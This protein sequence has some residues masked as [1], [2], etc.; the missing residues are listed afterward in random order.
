MVLEIVGNEL[1]VVNGLGERGPD[2]AKV[3]LACPEP[4]FSSK[5]AI[6]SPV[7]LRGVVGRSGSVA[8]QTCA[9]VS[10][11]VRLTAWLDVPEFLFPA[12]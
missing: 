8:A 10:I 7:R 3:V 4:F 12:D 9:E 5:N 11:A 1:L 6:S 2:G